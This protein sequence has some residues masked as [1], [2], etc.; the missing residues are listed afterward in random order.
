MLLSPILGNKLLKNL[1]VCVCY[2]FVTLLSDDVKKVDGIFFVSCN[3]KGTYYLQ[4]MN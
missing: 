2:I 4:K 1:Q 3:Q